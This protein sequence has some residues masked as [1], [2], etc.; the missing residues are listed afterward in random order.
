[1][2]C[3]VFCPQRTRFARRSLFS[4]RQ[5][6]GRITRITLATLQAYVPIL[7]PFASNFNSAGQIFLQGKTQSQFT[8]SAREQDVDFALPFPSLERFRAL[9]KHLPISIQYL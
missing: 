3:S 7:L 9:M 1:M 5:P 8:L 2:P 4:D 6:C